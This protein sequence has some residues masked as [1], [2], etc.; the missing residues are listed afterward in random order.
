M[1]TKRIIPCMDMKDGR[2]VK[3]IGFKDLRDAG[4]PAEL[5]AY[6]D[7]QGADEIV[8]LDISASYE[9]R[10]TLLDV[11]KRTS[12]KVFIP[13]MV[14]GG[15]R[16][17]Q[18]VRDV[19][20][21]GADKVA[22][23]TAIVKEPELIREASEMFGSQCIIASIDIRRVYVKDDEEAPGKVVLDTAKGKCWWDVYIYGGRTPVGID[24]IQW[25]EMAAALGAGEIVASSLDFDGTQEGYDLE[26]LRAV[27]ERV[28][29]PL[30]ASSGAGNPKH[31]LDAL[32]VGKADA[33][34]A[35]SIFHYGKYSIKEVKDY[36]ACNGIP[37]R[38]I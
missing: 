23:N 24:A 5:S 7:E 32:K 34:L 13:L 2:V 12:E 6:Y 1:L 37:I 16:T 26:F 15:I 20:F 18:D 25:A 3:G 33:V 14:G 11:V 9:N 27:S 17:V 28:S 8:L 30:I 38:P 35:A 21:N 19:L 10:G 29:I 36:L 22:I 31:L 4:D